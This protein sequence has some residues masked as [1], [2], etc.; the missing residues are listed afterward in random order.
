MWFKCRLC[1]R[2]GVPMVL[3]FKSR[4][5]VYTQCNCIEYIF[6]NSLKKYQGSGSS[7]V[8][9]L[10]T[11]HF[12][13]MKSLTETNNIT[14]PLTEL[15]LMKNNLQHFASHFQHIRENEHHLY[16]CSSTSCSPFNSALLSACYRKAYRQTS[17]TPSAFLRKGKC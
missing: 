1:K 17:L 16:S 8:L 15:V 14:K 10:R 6:L 13:K 4:N 7:P 2:N 3:C 11:D 12:C 5:V 9:F